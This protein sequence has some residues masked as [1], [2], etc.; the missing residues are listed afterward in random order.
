MTLFPI[1]QASP[2]TRTVHSIPKPPPRNTRPKISRCCWP[3]RLKE[4]HNERHFDQLILI[5]PPAFLGLLRKHLH[6]PLDKLV[7]R[8]I[9]KDLSTAGIENIIDYIRA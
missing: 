3:G 7:K 4:M 8:T 6:K 2:G 9:H 1:R 5:A